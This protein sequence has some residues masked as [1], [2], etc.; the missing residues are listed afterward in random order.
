MH[1]SENRNK[2]KKN[3]IKNEQSKKYIINRFFRINVRWNQIRFPVNL[4][5]SRFVFVTH[6]YSMHLFINITKGV[7]KDYFNC[8]VVFRVSIQV[9]LH[10]I[11][12]K[13]CQSC[14]T[15]HNSSVFNVHNPPYTTVFGSCSC[16]LCPCSG[17]RRATATATSSFTRLTRSSLRTVVCMA[18]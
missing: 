10:K 17:E 7:M 8:V 4:S 9:M 14:I 15:F 5:L 16:L 6:L 2:S 12:Q 11:F 13:L 1:Y 18:N 3:G